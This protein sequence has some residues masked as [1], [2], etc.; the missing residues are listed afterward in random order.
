ME[1]NMDFK[2]YIT[3]LSM[4]ALLGLGTVENPMTGK[5][6]KNPALVRFTIDTLDLLKEKTAG[7]LNEDERKMLEGTTANL[8]FQFLEMEKENDSNAEKTEEKKEKSE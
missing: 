7:N 1:V 3:F 4:N 5:K 8:K 6:E 2:E